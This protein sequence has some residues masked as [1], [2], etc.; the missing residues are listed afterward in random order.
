MIFLRTTDFL[1]AGEQRQIQI[2]RVLMTDS[3]G[4]MVA[5]LARKL[6]INRSTLKED[7]EK[8]QANLLRLDNAVEVVDEEN[9]IR[10]VINEQ[11]SFTKIIYSFLQRSLKYQILLHLLTS[12]QVSYGTLAETMSISLSTLTRKIRDLNA[13][14]NKYHLK[15][16]QG[17]IEGSEIAIRYFYFQLFWFGNPYQVNV[18]EFVNP[19]VKDLLSFLESN[20][21]YPF[22]EEGQVKLCI[23]LYITKCRFRNTKVSHELPL[24]EQLFT[25]LNRS[26]FV[27][28]Q[29][30]FIRF[31]SR[32]AFQWNQSESEYLYLFMIAN[33]TLELDNPHVQD[34][35]KI[36]K[37]NQKIDQMDK[38]FLEELYTHFDPSLLKDELTKKVYFTLLQVHYK[39]LYFPSFFSIWGNTNLQE[40]LEQVP[41]LA[42]QQLAN[43]MTEKTFSLIQSSKLGKRNFYAE[44]VKKELHNRYT[45][46]LHAIYNE[47]DIVLQ[48]GCDFPF[49]ASMNTII[50]ENIEERIN[51]RI[52][53]N[54]VRFRRGETYDAIITYKD[55]DALMTEIVPVYTLLSIEHNIDFPILENFLYQNY[56]N[57]INLK[58]NLQ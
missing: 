40:R 35:I 12:K 51:H 36:A 45:V 26:A 3:E 41:N 39:A 38:T 31:F 46:L 34:L 4:I 28:L 22:T 29:D 43:R 50:I 7:L 57:K 30:L 33:Y 5:N 24:P 58:V 13:I 49:E 14:L 9:L 54:F 20:L 47:L 48:V 32:Y 55:S 42:L 10:L 21:D 1:D 8:L 11:I 15:I 23:W 56:Q 17:K 44:S 16:H 18:D 53:V 52:K 27:G 25:D 2:I 6:T 37:S 19:S